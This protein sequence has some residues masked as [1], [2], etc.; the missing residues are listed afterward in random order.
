MNTPILNRDQSQPPDDGWYQFEVAGEHPAG[1]GRTQV[2]DQAAMESIVNRFREDAAS[3]GFAGMLVDIDHLSHDQ[4][5]STEAYGWLHEVECR[6]GQLWG[7]I[8]WTDLGEPAI[9]NKRVKYF[10][11]EYAADDLEPAGPGRVRPLRLGGLALTNRPNNKGGKPIANREQESTGPVTAGATD[12]DNNKMK[13]IAEKLG[14]PAEATEEQ[15]LEAIGMMQSELDGLKNKAM[16]AEAEAICNRHAAR[17]PDGKRE[18][19]KNA[20]LAN[21]ETAEA[22]LAGLPERQ[23]QPERI[24]NRA[25]ARNPETQSEKT[26]DAKGQADAVQAVMNRERCTFERAW[27]IARGEQP[28]LFV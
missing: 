14:L 9:R 17:I 10:S 2:I 4:R 22:L 13:T 12:N 5:H 18:D 1:P 23:E 19:W 16:D 27:E 24:H 21:R 8:E 26:V 7:R 11:T 28:A 20:I 6:D 3:P 25:S 15:I